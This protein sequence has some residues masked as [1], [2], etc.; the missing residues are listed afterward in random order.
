MNNTISAPCRGASRAVLALALAGSL[1]VAQGAAVDDIPEV[2]LAPVTVSALGGLAVPYDQTG[3]SVTAVDL[4]ELKKEGI[5]TLNDAL[6]TV[7]GVA[8]QPDGL[9][10]RGNVGNISIRGMSSARCLLPMMDGMRLNGVGGGNIAPNVVGRTDLFS[11][12][13]LE[14][15]RGAQGA[16][17][18]AGAMGG[19]IYMETPEGHGEPSLTLFNE[20]GSFDSYTGNAAAQ[21][22]VD[23]LAYYVSATYERTNNDIRFADGRPVTFRHAGYYDSWNEAIRLDY[24]I[25]ADNKLTLTYR[26]EDAEY[27]YVWPGGEGYADYSFRTNLLTAKLQSRVNEAYS[28]SLMAGYY[29]V[30]NCFGVGEN[31]NLRDVQLEWRNMYQWNEQHRTTAGMAW[32]RSEYRYLASWEGCDREN[33]LDNTYGFFVEHSYR[34]AENWDNSLALRWDRSS[35]WDNLF[36][37]R[38][39]SS[40]RFNQERTRV[41]GSL[42]SGYK[43]PYALQCRGVYDAGRTKY[44][45]NPELD[46]EQNISADIGLE[47]EWVKNHS[48]SVTL[49]W[50]RVTDAITEVPTADPAVRTY[51]NAASHWTSQGVELAAQGT[52]EEQWHTGYRLAFTYT[53][54]K[55]EQDGQQPLTARQLWSADIHTSPFED[56]TTGLGLTATVGR[57]GTAGWDGSIVPLDN[58]FIMRWYAR[59]QVNEHLSFHL[60]VENLLNQKFI[61][62][63]IWQ[64]GSHDQSGAILNSGAAVYAGCTL[65]F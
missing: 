2:E 51:A 16:V 33:T 48:V 60:R 7:P 54:P 5:E 3:V 29:G 53:Q 39:A 40:Y 4:P 43:T 17:Y 64:W 26:R 12:G 32:N 46:C 25:N 15:L 55:D 50:T 49:F 65:T 23:S 45:G 30:D 56:F 57:T 19:V 10:Q 38:A 62:E 22:K 35:V 1:S 41:F 27:R 59:Y 20:A 28:T 6:L 9:N 52:W 42:G 8:V 13:R 31:M 61:S 44:V 21:G 37:F 47:H 11:L 58:Y 18:G 34:P 24:D 63:Q 14:V 36:S